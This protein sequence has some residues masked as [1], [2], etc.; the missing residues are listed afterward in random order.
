MNHW[1]LSRDDEHIAWLVFDQ[2]GSGV[3][4]LSDETLAEFDA[5]LSELEANPPRG[6]VIRSAKSSGF[7]AGADVK[8]FAGMRDPKA[9][10]ALIRN[11]HALLFRLEQLPC[12]SVAAIQGF[13]LGGGLEL[14]LACTYRIVTDDAKTK[15]GF[16]EVRLGIFPGFGGSVRSIER[17]G[18]LAAMNMMLSGRNLSGR[19]AKKTGLATDCVPLRQLEVAC[20][21]VLHNRPMQRKPG[22]I[23]QAAG[24]P[25]LRGLI[26]TR[27]HKQVA[28][29]ANP[30]HYPAPYALIDHWR[31]HANSPAALYDSEVREVSRLLTG[32]TAQNL[33]RVFLL[34]EQL[35][36]Q[37]NKDAFIPRH[38]HVIGAG[39]MGGDIAAWGVL[40]GMTVSLQDRGAAQLARAMGRARELFTK[41]LKS[42]RLITDALDRLIPD[43]RGDGIAKADVVLE[44]IIEDV[45]AKQ[46]LFAQV[47][48]RMKPGALLATNTSSIQL[49]VLGETLPNPER[50]I[51]LHFFN[52]V[53]KMPLLEIVRGPNTDPAV[54]E[55]ALA[56][57]RHFNKLPLLVQSSPG[58]LVNRI[59]MPY[60]LEAVMLVEEGVAPD[61]IDRAATDYGMPMGPVELADTVGLDICLSV[62]GK[63]AALLKN[64]VP[65]SLQKHVD[66][67]HLGRKSGQGYYRWE[68]GRAQRGESTDYTAE[69]Q[70]R[71]MLRL[72]NEAVACL[73]ERVVANTDELDAGV[74]FGTGFAPF[75]GGPMQ[76]IEHTGATT[77]HARLVQLH[78]KLGTRF[79]PDSGWKTLTG[80]KP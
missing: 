25:A 33:V 77:L 54:V 42:P 63:M 37:G 20:R 30:A 71:I 55:Q 69:Q 17:V 75:K 46:G 9:A 43:A 13:C 53:A 35:K 8:R 3:N 65:A 62:A 66:A 40:Q 27:M 58:F 4:T 1:T 61:A 39:V 10:E 7:I 18:H 80:E 16:P 67:G 64:E 76:V 79:Q 59:L 56:F 23:Q 78:E 14:A 31:L 73:R 72:L 70:D 60:L 26:A 15:L 41:K 50:L 11:A 2:A 19:A 44:A 48:P 28:E 12:P 68:K 24:W 45:A 57:A 29:H 49:E 47:L 22:F 34:Q 38:L 74:I 36:S 51:G 32:D 52:P 21:H 6:L 5:A